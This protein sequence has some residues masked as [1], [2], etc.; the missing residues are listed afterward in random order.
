MATPVKCAQ[1]CHVHCQ[2][3]RTAK[4]LLAV[5]WRSGCTRSSNITC[6]M[7]AQKCQLS[8]R[9]EFLPVLSAACLLLSSHFVSSFKRRFVF[10]CMPKSD[11]A[12]GKSDL[13]LWHAAVPRCNFCISLMQEPAAAMACIYHVN[14]PSSTKYSVYINDIKK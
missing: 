9:D 10:L 11:K 5:A 6:S 12:A 13:M 1:L 7:L 14:R 2:S 4:G 8:C 3:S